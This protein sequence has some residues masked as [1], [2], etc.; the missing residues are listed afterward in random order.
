MIEVAAEISREAK[1]PMVIMNA[2]TSI[3]TTKSPYIVRV[4]FTLPQVTVP[5]AQW[6][7][8]HGIKQV[9]MMTSDYGPGHDAAN[10]FEK[11]FTA[12]GGRIVGKVAMPLATP[13]FAAYVQKAADAKPQAVFL[14]VPAGPQPVALMK[15]LAEQGLTHT[16]LKILATGDV[17]DDAVLQSMGDAALGIITAHHYS[18]VHDS[19]ENK[20]FVKAYVEAFG[21]QIRPAFN[22]V[23]GYD[24]MAA[25][26]QALAVVKGDVADPDKVM[27]AFKGMKI[28]SP[29]GP[30][31][32][33][34]A[35]RDVIQTVYIRRVAKVKGEIVNVEF[36]KIPDV[37]DPGKEK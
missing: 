18:Y 27:E 34:P 7:A 4:S 25:I 6:A 15:N 1:V 29:R 11:A 35:T 12:A 32:I 8:Q 19:S 31:S 23:G 33:D 24:G 14:F 20:A 5:L 37:K 3:I 10:A 28:D 13:D 36:D 9:Y 21:T 30:I 17:T 2:A 16:G 26:Y 22:A